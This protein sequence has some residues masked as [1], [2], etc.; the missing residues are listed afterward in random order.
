M[1]EMLESAPRELKCEDGFMLSE[2]KYRRSTMYKVR[3]KHWSPS[4]T[5][6]KDIQMV[7]SRVPGERR[8][9]RVR[10]Q[11]FCTQGRFTES[12][13]EGYVGTPLQIEKL[14]DGVLTATFLLQFGYMVKA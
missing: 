6:K 5:K 1:R 8:L 11:T 3:R 4:I 13:V 9:K 2:R 10:N 14:T 12:S 7:R